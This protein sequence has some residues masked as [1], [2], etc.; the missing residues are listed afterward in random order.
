[1]MDMILLMIL[2]FFGV[3]LWQWGRS[4]GRA[5]ATEQVQ[6][7]ASDV[8]QSGSGTTPMVLTRFYPSIRSFRSDAYLNSIVE[9]EDIE[10][11]W[12]AVAAAKVYFIRDSK[13]IEVTGMSSCRCR[14]AVSQTVCLKA[15]SIDGMQVQAKID[16]TVIA[17]PQ[18]LPSIAYPSILHS[19][20]IDSGT[21][22]IPSL[23]FPSLE[24]L[25]A[26]CGIISILDAEMRYVPTTL[27]LDPIQV[28]SQPQ[29][30]PKT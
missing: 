18:N 16:V 15:V 5:S 26:A 2:Y 8:H 1:M 17:L 13:T 11:A 20:S 6:P 22:S 9:G 4:L 28:D 30:L 27:A 23:T 12:E 14:L 21:N 3:L 29:N 10:F 7:D 19:F 24:L 25:Q